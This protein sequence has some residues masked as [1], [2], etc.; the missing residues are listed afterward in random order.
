MSFA[1]APRETLA[2]VGESGCGKSVTALSVM[3]LVPA[4]QGRIGDGRIALEGRELVGLPS[5]R[6]RSCAAHRMAMIFQEPMTSLN[7]V[8]T[9]GEQ[10]AES[11]VVHQRPVAARRPRRRRWRCWTR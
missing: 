9:I 5:P 8:M 6:W 7:P 1:L 11:L 4:P 10:V 2:L 3:G